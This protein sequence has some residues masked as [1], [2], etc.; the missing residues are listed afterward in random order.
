MGYAGGSKSIW[1][2]YKAIGDYTEAYRIEYDPTVINYRQI[3]E[4]FFEMQGE[5]VFMPNFS[6]Q[7]RSAILVHNVEQQ[8][9]ATGLIDEIKTKRGGKRPSTAVEVATDFY[10][11][12]EYHLKY[13]EKAMAA[14][15]AANAATTAAVKNGN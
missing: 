14:K 3:L 15:A 1:P 11:A 2:T 7:Y 12:E 5:D 13:Y 4:K 10:Q 9:I 6:R 8:L